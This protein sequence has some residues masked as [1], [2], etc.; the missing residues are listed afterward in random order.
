[1]A[2][3]THELVILPKASRDSRF[4]NRPLGGSYR[5][6]LPVGKMEEGFFIKRDP[7][8]CFIGI[9]DILRRGL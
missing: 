1:M 3:G 9:T 4:L 2:P 6:H 7:N 8:T 5:S